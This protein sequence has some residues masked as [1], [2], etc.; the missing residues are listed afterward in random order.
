MSKRAG[1][2]W[3]ND[4]ENIPIFLIL[5]M[6]Y[7]YAALPAM[8][9]LIYCV[10]FT[11][12]RIFHTIFFLRAAQPWRTIAFFVGQLATLALMVHLA[13]GVVLAGGD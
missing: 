13:A 2:A 10:V 12:A 3:R 9:F 7:V 8:P 1:H 6:I 11:V 4:L 5:G